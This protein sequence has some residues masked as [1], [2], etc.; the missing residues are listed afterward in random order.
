MSVASEKPL[1]IVGGGFAGTT[2]LLHT[3]LKASA[4]PDISASAPLQITLLERAP[5]QL[6][7]GIA[8]GQTPHHEYNLNLSAKRI[9]PFAKDE[10]PKGFPTMED[11]IESF[12]AEHPEVSSQYVNTSRQFYGQYLR[13]LIDLAIEKSNGKVAVA[14]RY[15]QAVDMHEHADGVDLKLESGD[16]INASRVVLATGFKEAVSPAFSFNVVSQPGYLDYPYSEAA[17]GFF[18]R[19]LEGKN[20][21]PDSRALVIGTGLSAMDSVNRLLDGGYQGKIT[22]ISRRGLMHAIY[23]QISDDP[24]ALLGGEPRDEAE[25]P[26]TQHRPDFIENMTHYASFDEMSKAFKKEIFQRLREGYTTEEILGHWEKFVPDVYRS[27]PDETADFLLKYETA[28]NVFRVG[29][30]PEL[31]DKILKAQQEG[32]VQII[33]GRIEDMQPTA[34]GMNVTWRPNN[35]HGQRVGPDRSEIYNTVINGI[36]NSTKYDLPANK[37]KDKLWSNL[38]ARDAYEVHAL[39]DGVAVTNDFRLINGDGH[40][41]QR[42]NVIGT[43]VSGHMNITAYPYPEKDG[44]G[45]RL[46]AFTL[47]IQGILGG[48]QAMVASNYEG[49]KQAQQQPREKTFAALPAAKLAAKPLPT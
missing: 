4:D 39:R 19:T 37:I 26:F 16:T 20:N 35:R 47:N 13:H 32:R 6:F 18:K 5:S 29:T 12:V 10:H 48:V 1:V 11:F 7:G 23:R 2:T 49:F 43:P 27:F 22:M 40:A 3:I 36:G 9:T 17:N 41:Y 46:G 34:K 33:S 45:A 25:L 30:T 38:R 42:V 8:Y 31:A 24:R 14:T 28:I 15:D 44:S 21:T